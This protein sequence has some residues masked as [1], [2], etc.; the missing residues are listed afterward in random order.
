LA[1]KIVSEQPPALPTMYSP[2]L[3]FLVMQMLQKPLK[4]RPT[5]IQLM[6]YA[7]VKYRMAEK[8]LKEKE[9]DMHKRFQDVESHLRSEFKAKYTQFVADQEEVVKE[10][11]TAT[12]K[13]ENL[14][15]QTHDKLLRAQKLLTQK[16]D[17]CAQLRAERGQVEKEH[18]ET[19][20]LIAAERDAARYGMKSVCVYAGVYAGQCYVEYAFFVYVHEHICICLRVCVCVERSC[21][22]RG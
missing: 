5:I 16:D 19:E 10:M 20:A 11:H 22:Q 8:Q 2:E 12:Q 18:A 7:P 6:N 14:T 3:R 1:K 9:R 17:E 21:V 15:R 13:Q 4:K